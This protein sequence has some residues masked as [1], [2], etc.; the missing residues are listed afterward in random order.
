LRKV[1]FATADHVS[2]DIPS[3]SLRNFDTAGVTVMVSGLGFGVHRLSPVV[4]K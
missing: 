1:E 3:N 2:V 4:L